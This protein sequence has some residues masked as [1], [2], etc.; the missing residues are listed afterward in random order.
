MPSTSIRKHQGTEANHCGRHVISTRTGISF[1]TG[2]LT[3]ELDFQIATD[4][5]RCGVRVWQS[6]AHRNHR[7]LCAA[8]HL[9]HMKVAVAVARIKKLNG[10]RDQ[11][12]ALSVVTNARASGGMADTVGRMQRVRDVIRER[13]SFKNPLSI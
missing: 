10:Y 8:R 4:G 11:E 3:G 5:R 7:K 9:K 6:G 12:I 13:G 2:S 1:L